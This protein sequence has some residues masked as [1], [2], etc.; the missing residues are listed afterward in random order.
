MSKDAIIERI[1]NLRAKAASA[2]SSE[3]EVISAAAM[4]S[5]LMAKHD[6]SEDELKR[7]DQSDIVEGSHNADRRTRH[8]AARTASVG[9]AKFTQTKD[10][11]ST[12]R[13]SEI[14]VGLDTDVLFAL[15]LI[16]LVQTSSERSWKRFRRM[17]AIP[18]KKRAEAKKSFLIS[19]GERISDRLFQMARERER[20]QSQAT[21]T[22]LV[23]V[24]DALIDTYVEEQWGGVSEGRASKP[25]ETD[26]VAYLAG[27]EA[28]ANLTLERPIEDGTEDEQE[29]LLN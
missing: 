29:E 1:V 21:G 17:S 13:G 3:A 27:W 26:L 14:F 28:A 22:S 20:A 5:K 9:I 16:E 4:V 18:A 7:S 23:V 8:W 11:Y 12:R 10:Y 19:Y 24:K 25:V 6:I 15:Y 2:A